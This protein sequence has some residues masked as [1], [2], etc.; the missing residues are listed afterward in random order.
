MECH[1][2]SSQHPYQKQEQYNTGEPFWDA[3]SLKILVKSK[4]RKLAQGR[5]KCNMKSK[6]TKKRKK[7]PTASNK[8]YITQKYVASIALASAQIRLPCKKF[9]F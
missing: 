3:T 8:L 6:V 1:P 4:S 7:I 5:R 9:Q 2:K